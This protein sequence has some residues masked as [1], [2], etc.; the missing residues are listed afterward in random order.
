MKLLLDTCCLLW[1]LQQPR[2][3]TARARLCLQ[4]PDNSVFVSSL[5]FWEISLK[6]SLGK[7]SIEGAELEEFPG[8]VGDAGWSILPFSPETV[9]SIA[10]LPRSD[11][12]KDPF[13]RMLIWTAIREDLTL[14]SKDRSLPA[15]ESFGLRLCG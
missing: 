2:K 5:S 9:A 6:A 1:A 7:M 13:D 3:L 10:R 4:D 15:Y 12:H 14:V 8:F 11:G